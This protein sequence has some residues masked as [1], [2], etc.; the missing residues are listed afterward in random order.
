MEDNVLILTSDGFGGAMQSI[1]AAK[2]IRNSTKLGKFV[3]IGYHARNEI[4]KPFRYCFDDLYTIH[5]LNQEDEQKCLNNDNYI[6]EL[7]KTYQCD[8]VYVIWPD[9][10]YRNKY[11]FDYKKY[12]ISI[13]TLKQTKVLQHKFK[14][15]DN[16]IY[17]NLFSSTPGYLYQ[18]IP[19]LIKQ[20]S[21]VLQD[22]T[23]HV[24]WITNWAGKS[25]NMGEIP[26]NL[27]KNVIIYNN[28]DFINRK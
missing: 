12:N 14:P 9:L 18:Q 7:A 1:Q 6:E 4:F 5:Q 26:D 17:I 25:I 3:H 2:Y 24:P 21:Y 19:E 27:N 20:L 10:L 8:E 23:I 28:P 16:N 11:S 22:Y 15:V 13:S